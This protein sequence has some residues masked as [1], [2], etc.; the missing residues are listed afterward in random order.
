MEGIEHIS[1]ARFPTFSRT[2]PYD[3]QKIHILESFVEQQNCKKSYG[4][5]L[6]FKHEIAVCIT[7]NE[8]VVT[9]CCCGTVQT[10]NAVFGHL[11][12]SCFCNQS[13]LLEI[14]LFTVGGFPRLDT[15]LVE[16]K[17][18]RETNNV[19]NAI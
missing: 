2:S 9:V 19:M 18:N 10:R 11:A 15:E 3:F 14:L 16:E 7:Q 5:K 13:H 17:K 8:E 4:T 1:I 6:A 12:Y